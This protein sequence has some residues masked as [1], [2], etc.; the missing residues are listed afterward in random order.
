MRPRRFPGQ[1]LHLCILFTER[2]VGGAALLRCSLPATGVNVRWLSVL[3][4]MTSEHNARVCSPHDFLTVRNWGEESK[5]GL[6]RKFP[7][8]RRASGIGRADSCSLH[9]SL[10]CLCPLPLLSHPHIPSHLHFFYMCIDI[11]LKGDTDGS[12]RKENRTLLE[13]VGRFKRELQQA[14]DE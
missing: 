10:L 13:Q 11:V 6:Y 3:F 7:A 4:L 8:M 9:A 14:H 2:S 1:M 5:A 12:F